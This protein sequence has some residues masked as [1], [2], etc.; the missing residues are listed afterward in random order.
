MGTNCTANKL[1][2]NSKCSFL[3]VPISQSQSIFCPED[4]GKFIDWWL[5]DAL[6]QKLLFPVAFQQKPPPK[7][8]RVYTPVSFIAKL[9]SFVWSRS[10]Q[11]MHS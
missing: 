10:Y 9:F 4:T 7:I 6:F 8:H 11:K 2:A 5:F 3:C 1:F